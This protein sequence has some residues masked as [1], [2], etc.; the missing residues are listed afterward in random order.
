MSGNFSP[1]R[2]FQQH[3][4]STEPVLAG[5]RDVMRSA[6]STSH[7][8]AVRTSPLVF[9]GCADLRA[10]SVMAPGDDSIGSSA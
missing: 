6:R 5:N 3:H 1:S 2:L 9:G 10:N 8:G 7:L 4:P